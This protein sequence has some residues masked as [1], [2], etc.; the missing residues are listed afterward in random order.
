MAMWTEDKDAK[1]KEVEKGNDNESEI[2]LSQSENEKEDGYSSDMDLRKMP[3]TIWSKDV[4]RKSDK[5]YGTPDDNRGR[6]SEGEEHSN[7][8]DRARKRRKLGKI[9][10][11][12]IGS[13]EV[14]PAKN[15]RASTQGRKEK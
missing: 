10:G 3:S 2:C 12:G 8:R 4:Q 11:G 15:T 14:S 9:G 5:G 7:E 1:K 6:E 13:V